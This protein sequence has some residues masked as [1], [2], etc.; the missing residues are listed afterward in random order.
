[1]PDVMLKSVSPLS[2]AAV[3]STPGISLGEDRDFVLTQ[4]AGFGKGFEKDLA[5]A[6]GKLPVRVGATQ[7]NDGFTVMRIAPQQVWCVG[8]ST[9][10]DLPAS[11]LVT[12][13][14]SGRCRLRLEGAKARAV[15]AR[16]LPVD[17]RE[18]TLKPGQFVM[19]GV[20]HTPVLV[21]CIE[22]NAFHIY[23]LRT[24]AVTVWEWL[25]DAGEG[26]SAER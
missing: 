3:F 17:V 11:C 16:A 6:I 22:A 2:G 14:S 20:H 7:E 1:M 9:L 21:H 25:V 23:A 10:P 15:L 8:V 4:V 26:L 19:T 13:L 18:Q 12:S 24:F 5:Q